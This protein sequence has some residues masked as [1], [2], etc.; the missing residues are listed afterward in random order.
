LLAGSARRLESRTS[1]RPQLD[2][3]ERM[4]VS[5]TPG[6]GD[7]QQRVYTRPG[8]TPSQLRDSCPHGHPIAPTEFLKGWSAATTRSVPK[9]KPRGY[10]IDPSRGGYRWPVTSRRRRI[11]AKAY[12]RKSEKES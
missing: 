3:P 2:P 9:D 6:R 5:F 10:D 11:P 7:T 12:P 4:E 8:A 1:T